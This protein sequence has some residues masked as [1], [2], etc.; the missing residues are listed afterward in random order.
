M[1][2]STPKGQ[3]DPTSTILEA[4]Q[5]V[6]EMQ[7]YLKK[8][9]EHLQKVEEVTQYFSQTQQ[10]IEEK[11]DGMTRMMQQWN[12][13]SEFSSAEKAPR[14]VLDS[15]SPP[16]NHRGTTLTAQE[17]AFLKQQEASGKILIHNTPPPNSHTTIETSSNQSF[18]FNNPDPH[19]TN[20][21]GIVYTINPY[22]TTHLN[23]KT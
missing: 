4:L 2:S 9:D 12:S 13:S 18:A 11:M 20:T 23:L 15:P 7:Q 6:H 14:I 19:P 16:P 5:V 21:S 22:Q 1:S 8:S 17:Y 3:V 10:K